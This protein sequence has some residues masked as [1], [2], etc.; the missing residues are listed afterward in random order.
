MSHLGTHPSV[1][2][3]WE[4]GGL[5]WEPPPLRWELGG[6]SVGFGGRPLS[7]PFFQILLFNMFWGKNNIFWHIFREFYV[8]CRSLHFS[9][10]FWFYCG[11]RSNSSIL[12]YYCC[13]QR[14]LTFFSYLQQFSTCFVKL[15]FKSKFK[16]LF[17]IFWTI[18]EL[19]EFFMFFTCLTFRSQGFAVCFACC[20][21]AAHRDL[22][23]I[24]LISPTQ[25]TLYFAC[26][27]Q[28]PPK[29]IYCAFVCLASTTH[30]DLL[31][32]LPVS[33]TPPTGIYHTFCTFLP[34]MHRELLCILY[35]CMFPPHHPQGLIV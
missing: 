9:N 2:A 31:C 21:H 1:G 30:R 12:C 3:R 27:S 26:F 23:C 33:P 32:A 15:T 16:M 13:I 35:H 34:H 10:N 18:F 7:P 8:F 24:F 25:S 4:L 14:F 20:S 5:R 29:G 17:L 11:L 22:L 28:T 19:F 6:S